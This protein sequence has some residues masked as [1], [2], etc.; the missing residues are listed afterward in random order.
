MN[1]SV[2]PVAPS[3]P[4]VTDAAAAVSGTPGE[5][6]KKNRK[7]LWFSL[8][9][10]G[11]V[12]VG[13]AVTA[14]LILIAPGTEAAGTN[15]GWQTGGIAAASIDNRLDSVKVTVSD[16]SESA[17]FS[18]R[19]LGA[20][21]NATELAS[22]IHSERPFWNVT[23]WFAEPLEANFTFNNEQTTQA[24]EEKLA[25]AYLA[26]S[27]AEVVFETSAKKYKVV[28]G[29]SG[30]GIDT[31]EVQEALQVLLNEGEPEGQITVETVEV[32]PAISDETATAF[33]E[34]LNKQ[35][36][37]A[38]FYV[39]EERTVEIT[40][41]EFASWVTI[42]P[43]GESLTVKVDQ[44]KIDAA[45][46]KL[47][48][49][50]NREAKTGSAVV[51]LAGNVLVETVPGQSKRVLKSTDGLSEQFVAAIQSGDAKVKLQVEETPYEVNKTTRSIEVNVTTQK[52]TLKENGRV[53][54]SWLVSTG[55]A[56]ADTELGRHKVFAHVREQTMRG[57]NAATG[58]SY[59]IPNVQ[60]AMYFNGD[61]AFHGVHW[62]D[63]WGERGSAG[64][65][66]MSNER[67]KQL[68]EWSPDGI[69]ILVHE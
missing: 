64:C 1:D 58:V 49:Q 29:A 66:G 9:G 21:I 61:Q 56:G 25:A 4:I 43:E 27:D 34:T 44:A 53:V 33:S 39:D 48:E 52:L 54:D 68:Y 16:G 8:A 15:V 59:D 40:P 69:D 36:A 50:V 30:L 41:E 35:V 62:R 47:A 67:A 14:S 38:G 55:L 23:K 26:P 28:A 63:N 18:A 31:Q 22:E 12:V 24:L 11:V 17:T 3:T 60:Y 37:V 45:T 65:V 46:T 57:R 51:D 10:A 6:A 5:P 2:D 19:E 7:A 32:L 42:L 20:E 13:A